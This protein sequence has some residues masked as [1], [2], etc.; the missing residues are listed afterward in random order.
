MLESLDPLGNISLVLQIAILLLLILA[1]P[2]VKAKGTKKNFMKHGYLTV[3]ALILH[4]ILI[5][6]VMIPSFTEGFGGF[7][8]LSIFDSFTVWSH[9]VLGTLAEVLGIV[10]VVL[11]ASKPLK[12]MACMKLKKAMLPL[13]IIWVISII[14]GALI[15]LLGML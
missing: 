15:H 2:Y 7:S 11:W 14:N 8:E 12:H 9:A 1:V 6:I 13:F 4:S 10:I 3:I 5:A